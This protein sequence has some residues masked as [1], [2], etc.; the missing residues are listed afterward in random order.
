MGMRMGCDGTTN[1]RLHSGSL[2]PRQGVSGASNQRKHGLRLYDSTFRSK[3]LVGTL[4][5]QDLTD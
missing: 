3:K 4:E 1:Y 2:R 5:E